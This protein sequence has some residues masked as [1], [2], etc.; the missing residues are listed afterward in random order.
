MSDADSMQRNREMQLKLVRRFGKLQKV[1]PGGLASFLIKVS[2]PDDRRRIV[3]TSGGLR[4]YI[5]PFTHLGQLILA[6]GRFEPE[7]EA[8]FRQYIKSGDTFLDIGT[9]EGYF[10]A[11]VS[12]IVGPTGMIISVE[13]QSRLCDIIEINLRLNDARNFRI[14]NNAIGGEEGEQGAINLWPSFNTGAS[15]ILRRYRFSRATQAFSFASVDRIMRECGRPRIDF[16]KVDVEGFEAQVVKRLIPHLKARQINRLFVDYH[17]P[18][19][20]ANNI[21]PRGIHDSIINTG[22]RL[23]QGDPANLQSYILYESP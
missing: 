21:D 7:T 9:N 10:S 11:L 8:V 6:D 19:L 16:V 5:D 15:S 13:P 4:V 18:V 20:I 3:S 14:Y 1:R 23:V 12:T 17:A 2:A 22:Y